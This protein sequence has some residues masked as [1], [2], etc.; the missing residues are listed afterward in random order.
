MNY[1]LILCPFVEEDNKEKEATAVDSNEPDFCGGEFRYPRTCS[2]SDCEYTARWEYDEEKDSVKF[3]VKTIHTK[4]RWTGIG[5][6]KDTRMV[7]IKK[8]VKETPGYS[9][10]GI[11]KDRLYVNNRENASKNSFCAISKF[12]RIIFELK[13]V[14]LNCDNS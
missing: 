9:N 14:I 12:Q 4:N 6:S 5:F 11:S 7:S 13:C 2:G 10:M 1:L 3:I 8:I